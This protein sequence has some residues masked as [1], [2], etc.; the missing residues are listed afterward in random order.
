MMSDEK[1]ISVKGEDYPEVWERF[2]EL[3]DR[4]KDNHRYIIEFK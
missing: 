3:L 1:T 2:S 4:I